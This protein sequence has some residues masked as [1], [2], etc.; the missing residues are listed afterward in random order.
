MGDF[1]SLAADTRERITTP[2]EGQATLSVPFYF[3]QNIDIVV[4]REDAPDTN[5]WTDLQELHDYTLTGAAVSGGGTVTLTPAADGATRYRVRGL[6]QIYRTVSVVA[7]GKYSSAQLDNEVLRTRIIEQESRRDAD[8]LLSQFAAITASVAST[9]AN[10]LSASL[11]AAQAIAIA[12]GFAA[13]SLLFNT[14][15]DAAAA[16]VP[17]NVKGV[18]THGYSA[19]GDYGHGRYVRV[20]SAALALGGFRSVDRFMPDGSTDAVNGGYW[21]LAEPEPRIEQFGGKGDNTTF[22]D[23]A[24]LAAK[25]YL[26]SDP[27]VIVAGP[28]TAYNSRQIRM[29]HG[30]YRIRKNV[31]DL[32]DF[33]NL[34]IIGGGSRNYQ[35][36]QKAPSAIVIDG[37]GTANSGDFGLKLQGPVIDT[38][39]NIHFR[40]ISI[41]YD[42]NFG[43]DLLR[44]D[45][46][47]V[48]GF[49][50]WFGSTTNGVYT[51]VR[52]LNL[53]NG[54]HFGF[55][56]CSFDSAQIGAYIN[57]DSPNGAT[58]GWG[59]I[60]CP[61]YD[62]TNAAVRCSGTS[63][64]GVGMLAC[65]FDP[66]LASPQY[67]IQLLA[68]GYTI[69]AC[70]FTGSGLGVGPS[71]ACIY[72]NS[73]AGTGS[74]SDNDFGTNRA[75]PCLV[76]ASGA[77]EFANNTVNC[78]L[79]IVMTGGQLSGGG[80]VYSHE[81]ADA[82]DVAVDIQ[83]GSSVRIGPDR[84][85]DGGGSTVQF[86]NSYKIGGGAGVIRYNKALDLST[87]GPL[88]VDQSG[89]VR[90]DP[91]AIVTED[92]SNTTRTV[93][94]RDVGTKFI[95][96]SA[97][98]TVN[99][100]DS[101]KLAGNL[102]WDFIKT[103]NHT[104]TVNAGSG[105]DIVDGSTTAK[106]TVGNSANE[107]GAR[108]R[109]T[110]LSGSRSIFDAN[111][112]TWA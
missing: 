102:W 67:N 85:D 91:D 49:N 95:V 37:G 78:R 21:G 15:A 34:G 55:I 82:N 23:A 40:D 6:A 111:I 11:S 16:E 87:D 63:A 1:I 88:Y 44:G 96:A 105:T 3:A 101:T 72:A 83:G 90:L 54:H 106:S 27:L 38:S 52:L 28:A 93:T 69:K 35:S 73:G 14:F 109:L 62:F 8:S 48:T 92:I 61:F 22:N 94:V 18:I 79:G 36:Y 74:V 108:L 103:G 26:Q 13:S 70:L 53:F 33:I 98:A 32:G 60:C 84:F 76:L 110:A 46:A 41:M 71:I 56:F 107:I 100:P 19:A 24:W 47:G 77:C 5:V 29:Q 17:A 112:G 68:A 10:A 97:N 43:G 57:N 12:A 99:L 80:N 50:C 7:A 58:N 81:S 89:A 104:F 20:A 59:F 86:K 66:I 4:S 64:A 25:A 39:R 2:T 31:L 42:N 45:A 65:Q 9:A 30:Y 51:C 75:G